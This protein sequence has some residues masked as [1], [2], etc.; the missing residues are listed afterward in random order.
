MA[1][2]P[3]IEADQ[4]TEAAQSGLARVK[5]GLGLVP[6]MAKAMANSPVVVDAWFSLNSTLAGGGLDAKL[7]EKLALSVAELNECDYCLSA[8]TAIGGIVGIGEEEISAARRCVSPNSKESAA[9]R[10]AKAI[11]DSRGAVTD[12]ELAAVKDAGFGEGEIA[13]ILGAVVLSIFTNYF[14]RLAQTD[15]DFPVVRARQAAAA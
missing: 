4:A 2:L 15:I 1:R 14:N 12:Q 11:V 3:L 8:H 7:R 9:L 13:E 6:N 10:F 5:A